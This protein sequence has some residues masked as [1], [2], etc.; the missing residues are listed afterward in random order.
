MLQA[1]VVIIPSFANVFKLV[2]LNSTQW[3]YTILISISPIV[4]IEIQKRLNDFRFGKVIY[5]RDGETLSQG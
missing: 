4:I 3:I 2:P 5:K 1:I